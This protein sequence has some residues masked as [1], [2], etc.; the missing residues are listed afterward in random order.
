MPLR[1][2]CLAFAALALLPIPVAAQDNAEAKPPA[3]VVAI[4]VD[5]L[6]ADLF[7]QYRRHFTGGLARLASGAVFPSGYQSHAATETCP[8]H[9]TILTGTRPARNG[10]VANNWLDPASPRADKRIYCAEDERDARSSVRDPVVSAWHLKSPTLG[11]LMKRADP[12]SRVVAVAGKDRSAMMLG[13]HD[14]DAVYWWNRSAFAMHEETA[15]PTPV[16]RLNREIATRVTAGEAAY[17][18]PAWCEA[19]DRPVRIGGFTIGTG[20]F[21]LAAGEAQ[22]F[23]TSPRLD[24]ATADIAIAMIDAHELGRDASPDVLALGLSATD[25]IGH[26]YGHEGAEMCIQLAALDMAIGRLFDALDKRGIDYVAVLTADHGGLDA[27]ERLQQQGYPQAARVSDLPDLAVIAAQASAQSGVA[28][29][30]E[31]LLHGSAADIY[32][33]AAV[34]GEDRARLAAAAAGIVRAHPQVEAVHTRADLAATAMPEGSPQ[35]WTLAQRL[36]ASFD[37]VRSPDVQAV[38]KRGVVPFAAREGLTTT[39]GSPWDYDRRVPIAFWRAGI[40]AMEQPNPVETV[41]IAPT[42]AALL[43]LALPDGTFDGR[44]LDIDAGAADICRP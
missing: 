6:S 40:T 25:Y 35:D 10:I 36:R 4:A 21:A 42:L 8:G 26:A 44:C 32:I 13:G 43:R 3:L 18:V 37:P 16:E 1:I 29:G 9:A 23:T 24:D 14:A 11:T 38:L 34:T 27:P 41:D 20:R 7:A 2:L 39:H 17:D 15:L 33:D 19:V 31:P 30:T 5:Q 22:G 12:R 28:A